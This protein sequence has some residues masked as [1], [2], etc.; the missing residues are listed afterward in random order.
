LPLYEP[1]YKR[2]DHGASD[3]DHRNVIV[4][5]YVWKF[6]TVNAGPRAFKAVVNGWQTT[7]LVQKRSGDAL[8]ITSGTNN[9][10]T[11]LGR[12]R[13]VYSGAQVYGTAAC[14]TATTPHAA[15]GSFPRLS[16]P[17]QPMPAT[18]PSPT[19]TS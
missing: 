11:S 15:D 1:N 10:G 5:S 2:L 9:S 4:A 13:A 7:G 14:A 12:D 6:P 3:F 17:I 18:R 16:Q 8:T 19:G